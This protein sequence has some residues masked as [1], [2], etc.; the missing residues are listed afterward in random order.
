MPEHRLLINPEEI[1]QVEVVCAQCQ[2]VTS[3]PVGLPGREADI[4]TLH[5][6]LSHCP[7]CQTLRPDGFEELVK[8]LLADCTVLQRRDE[9]RIRFVVKQ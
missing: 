8:R 4:L 1:M 5:H 9:F 3:I 6:L 7:W 2:H